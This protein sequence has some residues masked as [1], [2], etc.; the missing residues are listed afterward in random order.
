M[1]NIAVRIITVV[2]LLTWLFVIKTSGTYGSKYIKTLI[3]LLIFTEVIRYLIESLAVY[4]MLFSVNKNI[5]LSAVA[6]IIRTLSLLFVVEIHDHTS[7]NSNLARLLDYQSS[8]SL[9]S[10]VFDKHPHAVV[11]TNLKEEIFYVNPQ[12]LE[13]TGYI[14]SE[15]IGK[16]PRIFQS[17]N[18]NRNIYKEM[19]DSLIKYKIWE[20]EFINKKKNGEIFQEH[21]RIVTLK[22]VNDNPRFYLA[23]KTDITKEKEYLNKVEYYSNYDGLTGL[24]RR[25]YFINLMEKMNF[26]NGSNNHFFCL[27]DIDKFK[28]INDIY[29]HFVGDL[30]LKHFSDILKRNFNESAY[31]CRF[32]GDEFAIYIFDKSDFEV[33]EMFDKFIK[34]LNENVLETNDNTVPLVTSVGTTKINLPFIFNDVY[35]RADKFLYESKK[36]IESNIVKDY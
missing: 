17:G 31:I 15:V 18:T 28:K 35:D 21:V 3:Y 4:E 11:L 32:G 27:L 7:I 29:G 33:T 16:T 9:L 20:G 25:S 8:T 19:K 26:E 24:Y 2:S 34:E 1:G 13:N 23:I 14:E 22:D 5:W 6:F 10:L 30:A 12:A 36:S